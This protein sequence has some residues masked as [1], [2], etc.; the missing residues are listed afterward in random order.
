MQNLTN[1]FTKKLELWFDE[2]S[3]AN[4]HIK[5]C[6]GYVSPAKQ[7]ELWRNGHS[8][9]QIDHQIAMLEQMECHNIAFIL[10]STKS[11]VGPFTTDVLPGC[12][13]YNWGEVITFDLI[14]NITQKIFRERDEEYKLAAK[15]AKKVGLTSGYFFK[16]LERPRVIQLHSAPSILH[17]FSIQEIDAKLGE[18]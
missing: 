13:W 10:Q 14:D 16:D 4:L 9:N 17:V 8:D 15:L 18:E 6:Q 3:K 5:I 7:A 2:L 11:N 12:S 1:E